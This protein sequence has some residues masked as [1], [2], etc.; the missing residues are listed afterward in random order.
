[1]KNNS[2]KYIEIYNF[3]FPMWCILLFYNSQ[4]YI[5]VPYIAAYFGYLKIFFFVSHLFSFLHTCNTSA[6]FIIIIKI[7]V[8]KRKMYMRNYP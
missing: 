5:V 4:P 3:Q 8:E 1:M 2:K 6:F 7:S